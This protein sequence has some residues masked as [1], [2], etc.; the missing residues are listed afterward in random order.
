MVGS[1]LMERMQ[2]EGDFAHF[3][4]V[5][6]TTSN[7]G[8]AGP[9][10]GGAGGSKLL[11]AKSTEALKGMDTVVTCQGGDYTNEVYPQL[12]AAGWQGYWIDAASA[13]R[14]KDDAIIVL[15][16]VNLHVIKQA[17]SRGI[18]NYVGGNCTV[19]LM[20]MGLQGLFH[21]GLVEWM[22]SMTYQAASGAGA[23][24]MRELLKQM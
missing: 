4:P 6:F 23:Q 10:L 24:N 11:D 7:V 5:F 8:G 22:T 13:L 14:M 21:A 17:L 1:V 20:L 3:E 18:K 12:R 2:A 15:D 16:P 19:S 9:K